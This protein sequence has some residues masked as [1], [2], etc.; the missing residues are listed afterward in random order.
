[1]KIRSQRCLMCGTE[2]TIENFKEE[3]PA[4]VDW[5]FHDGK[6]CVEGFRILQEVVKSNRSVHSPEIV[7]HCK[8]CDG[9]RMAHFIPETWAKELAK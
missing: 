6:I 5:C 3:P 7:E 9:C 2:W 4:T 1:M 8:S